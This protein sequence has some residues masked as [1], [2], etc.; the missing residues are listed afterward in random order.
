M[1]LRAA[2]PQQSLRAVGQHCAL[3]RLSLRTGLRCFARPW[4]SSASP[5]GSSPFGTAS[6]IGAGKSS[7][8]PA[9]DEDEDEDEDDEEET[10]DE[11]GDAL[12]TGALDLEADGELDDID[13]EDEDEDAEEDQPP[14]LQTGGV[15]WG[16]RA[17]AAAQALLATPPFAALE[18][19]SFRVVPRSGRVVVRLDKPG[20]R[21]G[22]PSL[23]ELSAF[24]T[25]FDAAL[26]AAALEP[27]ELSVEVSSAGAEREVRVPKDLQR[28]VGRPMRVVYTA[29][30]AEAIEFLEL[31]AYDAQLQTTVWKLA[32][33]RENKA[34][35]K[36]GQQM[37]KKQ[38][39]RRLELR[40]EQLK[41]L[42]LLVV[43]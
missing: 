25:A 29:D 5:R 11:E 21:I 41:L 12:F 33:C 7:K 14:G 34:N 4:T 27:D 10:D 39:E 37:S 40:T 8:P 20:D 43:V 1:T 30:G 38:R 18:L 36:K 31:L 23:D 3:E 9:S 32:D 6:R 16:D 28:F 24:S 13:D 17:L 19:Y 15:A 35:L 22:S 26:D 2:R 42:N